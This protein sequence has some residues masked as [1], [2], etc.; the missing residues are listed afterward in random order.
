MKVILVL[1]ACALGGRSGNVSFIFCLAS[2]QVT[3]NDIDYFLWNSRTT[4]ERLWPNNFGNNIDNNAPLK[5]LMHGWTHDI[6]SFW[7]PFV[8]DSYVRTGH[9]VIALDWS[10]T[11]QLPFPIATDVTRLDALGVHIARFI[12]GLSS[13]RGIPF[14]RI[15]LIGHSLGAHLAG[16]AGDNLQRISGSRLRRITGLDPAGMQF[17]YFPNRDRLSPDD[18]DQVDTI[19]TD[20]GPT[21]A[22][23]FRSI[24]HVNFW[25]N[26]GIAVQPGCAYCKYIYCCT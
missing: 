3:E 19:L 13:A 9:N 26:G 10:S 23:I 18:A 8:I 5:I 22:G 6:T 11:A 2:A 24:G 4:Q 21:G 12:I 15:H 20:A 25:P 7:Y 1:L 17:T 14:S 16:F